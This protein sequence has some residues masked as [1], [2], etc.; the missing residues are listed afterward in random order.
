MEKFAIGVLV[1][2][3]L[4]ALLIANNCKVR[5]LVQKGQEEIQNKLNQMMDEKLCAMERGA[6]TPQ[7][8]PTDD[9]QGEQR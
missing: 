4:G 2:G 9:E 8:Y 6:A 7:Y 5:Q 3:A 1:G